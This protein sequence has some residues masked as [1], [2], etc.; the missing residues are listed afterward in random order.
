MIPNQ[1]NT[2]NTV[3]KNGS[4]SSAARLLGV[5]SAAISKSISQLEKNLELRLFHRSTHSLTLT[6][7]GQELYKRTGHLIEQL[8]DQIRLSTDKQKSPHG[9]LKV[10]LPDSFGRMFVLPLVPAFL[11][12]YPDVELDLKFDDR[13]GDLVKEGADVGIGVLGN[14][15]SSLIAREFYSLQPVL[16]ASRDYLLKYGEPTTP[17]D[18]LQHNCI[19]YRSNTTG[20][21][22]LWNFRTDGEQIQ[23]EPEG[24]LIVNNLSAAMTAVET[25]VGIAA[26]GVGNYGA[27][28]EQGGFRRVLRGYESDPIKVMIY[29]SSRHYLPAKTRAFIDYMIAN[30]Q[31]KCPLELE[32]MIHAL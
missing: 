17:Q 14:D 26:V 32:E 2:F 11:E 23:M 15:D 29:Y 12:K 31:E 25:G 9:R 21:K 10:N 1:L 27:C 20:K 16:V 24:N 4:F 13:M 5:S 28:L 6:E 8:E 22:K 7:D 3:V 30:V 19:A 18:L